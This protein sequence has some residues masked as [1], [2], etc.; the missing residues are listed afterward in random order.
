[1][2]F[3]AVEKILLSR[4]ML[5]AGYIKKIIMIETGLNH[6]TLTKVIGELLIERGISYGK[7]KGPK[8]TYLTCRTSK[9]HSSIIMYLYVKLAKS[10]NYD[11]FKNINV[12][13]LNEAYRQYCFIISDIM[14]FT[15]KTKSDL[16]NLLD[17]NDAWYLANELRS[18]ESNFAICNVCKNTY[19]YSI[20]QRS[21]I[22]C[23]FC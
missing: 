2:K 15:E 5:E 18:K 14:N 23:P 9:Y 22:T 11:V 1:M 16:S 6:K 21:K 4:E 3:K 13:I 19:F 20:N 8:K 7:S 10:V 17:I 12:S